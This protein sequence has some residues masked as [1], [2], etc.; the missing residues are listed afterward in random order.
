[1]KLEIKS[2]HHNIE[3]SNESDDLDIQDW[4]QIMASALYGITF[5]HDTIMEGM[6][7]YLQENGYYEQQNKE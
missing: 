4:L 1:M 3:F 2:Y 5:S 7:Q 6:D